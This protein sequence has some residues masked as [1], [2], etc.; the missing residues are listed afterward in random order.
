MAPIDRFE[1]GDVAGTAVAVCARNFLLF[2]GLL[3]L[4]FAPTALWRGI[5][6]GGDLG[7][8]VN[9]E[10]PLQLDFIG[11][12][13]TP[14]GMVWMQAGVMYGVIR[15]LRGGRAGFVE[16]ATQA[17][18]ATPH[19]AIVTVLA[20]LATVVGYLCLV[21]P[22]VVLFL[23][24]W[25]ALPVAVVERR[26]GS[27]LGRSYRLTNGCK[28]RILGLTLLYAVPA[29]VLV[30]VIGLSLPL[31]GWQD[32]TSATTVMLFLNFLAQAF[33]ATLTA[34]AYHRLRSLEEGPDGA[35]ARVFD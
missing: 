32:A 6:D 7:L 4:A 14:L 21:V 33:W 35:I 29:L 30:I 25:V 10:R 12:L 3:L 34:V 11:A 20:G 22:G 18:R 31:A 17:F 2:G 5:A 19:V 26:F 24:F 9:G 13:L 23:M 1:V 16:L 8:W 28:W 27:A 15:D